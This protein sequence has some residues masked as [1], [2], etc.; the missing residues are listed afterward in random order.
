[1]TKIYFK[2]KI[3]KFLDHTIV[4]VFMTL[5]TIYALYLDDVKILF[6]PKS[7]DDVFSGIT[8]SVM[9]CFC[10]EIFLAFYSKQEYRFSF[11][12]YLDIISTISMIP[13]C[14]WIWTA[15]VDTSSTTN[16]GS[17]ASSATGLA[18]TSRAGRV[19]RII[20]ILRLIRL[21]RIVKLYKQK[22][23]AEKRAAQIRD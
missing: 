17:S 16:D 19:T 8:L 9:L 21:I 1:M 11:F 13:D 12:F 20:R 14:E 2:D 3:S 23:L 4:V 15:I 18:K 6:M 7:V 22:Q 5:I 10:L